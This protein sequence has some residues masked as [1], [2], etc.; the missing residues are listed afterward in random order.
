MTYEVHGRLQSEKPK[1]F[2]GPGRLSRIEGA[3]G[4]KLTSTTAWECSFINL[5]SVRTFTEVRTLFSSYRPC[6]R[7]P[8]PRL[9]VLWAK[10]FTILMC[11]LAVVSV[12]GC[13]SAAG[14]STTGTTNTGTAAT[15]TGASVALSALSCSNASMTG[16]G[17]DTCTV[18]L[19]SVAGSSG[20][21]VALASSNA[22]VTVPATVA[23]A[24]NATSAG[25]TATASSV[26]AAQSVTLTASAGGVS[27]TFALQLNA[28][29]TT[30]PTLTIS[31]TSLAFGNV[32]VNTPS[33]LP[34]TLTSAG[35][36]PVTI[37]SATLSGTGFTMSGATFPV[38][39][40]P[41][42]AVTLEVQF[43]P[44]TAGALTG[45]LTIQSNSSTN[46]TAVIGLSGTG[47]SASG[48]H[49]VTLNWDAPSS[50]SDPVVGYDIYRATGGSSTYQLLNSSAD[51]QTTYVDTAV[52]ASATYVYYVT[53]VDSSGVQSTSSNQVTATIP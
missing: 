39:L 6:K 48:S 44:T 12:S 23:V 35:T 20:V 22:A 7:G 34:V 17:S 33:T 50:S 15:G 28:A 30:V 45:Q 3:A 32:T 18:T 5:G 4:P 36:A 2:T 8:I 10:L 51:T 9:D 40:N 19:S 24:A 13:G 14:S 42:L 47:A 1:A 29:G 49:Q 41:S 38:T 31:A 52:Q 25:F 16:A 37:N 11:C 43:D 21:S 46:G 27:K 26:T 53:S